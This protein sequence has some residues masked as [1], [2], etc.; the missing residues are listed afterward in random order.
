MVK[1]RLTRVGTKNSPKYRIVAVDSRTKRD[2]KFL[3]I[4]GEYDPTLAVFKINVKKE[5]VA[6]WVGLGA[7]MSDTVKRLIHD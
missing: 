7:Q 3:E 6:H 2:G 4:L 5:R 1:I